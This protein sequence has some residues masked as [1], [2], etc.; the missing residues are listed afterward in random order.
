MNVYVREKRQEEEWYLC[1]NSRISHMLQ[2]VIEIFCICK[3]RKTEN[4][5]ELIVPNIQHKKIEKRIKKKLE[6]IQTEYKKI[7]V[8]L[9]KE[10]KKIPIHLEEYKI[11]E[12]KKIKKYFLENIFQK[13]EEISKVSLKGENIYFCMDNYHMENIQMIKN[14]LE[15][16]KSISI[17]T[18]EV[19]K[20][21]PLEE[22]L[23]EEGY[24]LSISN[25]KNKGL[26]KAKIIVNV[27]F[28]IERVKEF[29]IN[30]NAMVIQL[31]Q[32]KL[33]DIIRI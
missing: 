26:K 7:Q 3:I 23:L 25:N 6:I 17:I 19:K 30:R 14:F 18:R 31:G 9:S 1:S 29:K 11:V 27:D 24:L 16:F 32:E 12:G 20:F 8:I 28:S 22:K 4:K 13:M 5:I 33:Q 10:V 15:R 2:K 21:K